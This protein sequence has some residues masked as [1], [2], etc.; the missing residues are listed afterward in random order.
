MSHF[1]SFVTVKAV[2]INETIY[3][4]P[5]QFFVV[6]TEMVEAGSFEL[7]LLFNGSLEKGILGFYYSEYTDGNGQTR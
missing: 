1:F 5:H 3:Y 6:R 7:T 4:E 2:K